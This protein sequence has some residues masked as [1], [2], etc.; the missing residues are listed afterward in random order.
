MGLKSGL[1]GG[2]RYR[3]RKLGG[4]AEQS[5]RQ[6]LVV[7]PYAQFPPKA[8]G[9]SGTIPP[10]IPDRGTSPMGFYRA[11]GVPIP[12]RPPSQAPGPGTS[13]GFPAPSRL[14]LSRW[15]AC[16]LTGRGR[17]GPLPRAQRECPMGRSQDALPSPIPR[18]AVRCAPWVQARSAQ[19]EA[20][21]PPPRGR[22]LPRASYGLLGARRPP[23]VS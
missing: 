14:G 13:T 2:Y 10:A 19:E 16:L 11:W 5:S 15:S 7:L 18:T 17:R 22:G 4:S 20:A 3:Y 12:P 1:S 6:S 8:L 23:G 9:P 21:S